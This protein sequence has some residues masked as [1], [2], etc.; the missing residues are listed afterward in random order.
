MFGPRT[1]L[2]FGGT[3]AI[4]SGTLSALGSKLS[5][6]TSWRYKR[7]AGKFATGACKSKVRAQARLRE[8]TSAAVGTDDTLVKSKG[9]KAAVRF[10]MDAKSSKIAYIVLLSARGSE[11]SPITS[12]RY[13]REAGKS[14]TGACKRRVR[15]QARLWGKTSAAVGTDDTL[16]K[17]KG[18]KAA[19]RFVMDA[20]SS[21]IA[22]IVLLSARG[23]KL[24]PMTS[25]RYK[26]EAGKS[27]MGACK[28][29]V[30]AQAQLWG[31]T[32]A[33]AGADDTIVKSKGDKAVV[34]FVMD[35]KSGRIA[36]IVLLV[37]QDCKG[38]TDWLSGYG[39]C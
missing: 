7:E 37:E 26:R 39:F 21:K 16:V 22:Y 3:S 36:I 32:S 2:S 17:S 35:A 25:W 1:V 23:S 33:A 18:D 14:A 5:R 6:M 9:D 11:S 31:R 24:S 13:K 30:R 10:V 8:R 12:W 15:A 4:G 34:R 19:V 38:F 20:K 29:R 28:H 27:A